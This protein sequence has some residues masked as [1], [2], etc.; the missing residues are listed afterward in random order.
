[1][2][3]LVLNNWALI[4]TVPVC[5]LSVYKCTKLNTR[6]NGNVHLY[7]PRHDFRTGLT[8]P[9]LYN[10]RRWLQVGNFGLRRY[11]YNSIREATNKDAD[12]LRSYCEA[13]LCLCFRIIMRNVCFLMMNSDNVF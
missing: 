10:H 6:N 12:Q 13:D 2:T 8:Q 4:A 5:C 11:S 9:E 1:M 7:E 3:S